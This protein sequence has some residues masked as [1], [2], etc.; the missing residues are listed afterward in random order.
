MIPEG[1]RREHVE[2]AM[3][4]IDLEGIPRFRESRDFDLRHTTSYTKKD[5]WS[6][7]THIGRNTHCARPAELG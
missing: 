1:L 6:T 5:Y 3:S 4:R 2:A 7:E